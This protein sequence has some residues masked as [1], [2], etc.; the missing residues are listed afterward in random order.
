MLAVVVVFVVV[1]TV[2]VVAMV[3]GFVVVLTVV[4]L[5]VIIRHH[6]SDSVTSVRGISVGAYEA[7]GPNKRD[8]NKHCQ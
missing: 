6:V 3:V 5:T 7:T 1:F 2:V 8:D 4:M